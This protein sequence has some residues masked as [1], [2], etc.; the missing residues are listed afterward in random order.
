MM[1][2]GVWGIIPEDH[3]GSAVLHIYTGLS[4]Y[5]YIATELVS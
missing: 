2:L 3:L 1:K 4:L 5:I